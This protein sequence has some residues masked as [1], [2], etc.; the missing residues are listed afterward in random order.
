MNF[1]NLVKSIEE[2]ETVVIYGKRGDVVVIEHSFD[3]IYTV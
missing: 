3:Y 2:N 1:K